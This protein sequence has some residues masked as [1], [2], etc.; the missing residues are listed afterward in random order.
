MEELFD[1]CLLGV[2]HQG[3]H[4]IVIGL[5]PHVCCAVAR[6]KDIPCLIDKAYISITLE[7]GGEGREG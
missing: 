6:A 1:G 3:G 2:E 7:G 5:F 4:V